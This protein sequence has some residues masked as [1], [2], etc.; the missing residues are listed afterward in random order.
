MNRNT[1]NVAFNAQFGTGS[2]S[3]W[4]M[5]I[6]ETKYRKKYSGHDPHG[7][8]ERE[9]KLDLY[10]RKRHVGDKKRDLQASYWQG[11]LM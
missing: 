1:G 4:L 3:I 9:R 11:S 6:L 2:G 10:D 7:H 5:A 8:G